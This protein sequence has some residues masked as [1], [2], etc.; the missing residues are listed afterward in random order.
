MCRAKVAVVMLRFPVLAAIA[1]L[2]MLTFAA[3]CQGGLAD[4]G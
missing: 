3:I 1:M 4:L 2:P